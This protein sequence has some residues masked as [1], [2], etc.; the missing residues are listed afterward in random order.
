MGTRSG[1]RG[2]GMWT[3]HCGKV[4]MGVWWNGMGTED[5][6]EIGIGLGTGAS[7]AGEIDAGRRRS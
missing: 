7:R 1:R 3:G 4:R 6:W 5:G 2:Y